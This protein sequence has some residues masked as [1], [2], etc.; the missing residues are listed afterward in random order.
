MMMRYSFN[1]EDAAV[2][3]EEAVEEV[4]NN[5]LRT[6]DIFNRDQPN[7]KLVTCSGMGDA[8]LEVLKAKERPAGTEEDQID[9]RLR[10]KPETPEE[11]EPPK[12]KKKTLD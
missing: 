11:G 9:E 4:L 1:M 3:I 7:T 12:L 10:Q 5:G 8:V 2:F 6:A